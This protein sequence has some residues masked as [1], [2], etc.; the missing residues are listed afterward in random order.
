M[1]M[2]TRRAAEA[3]RER[4]EDKSVGSKRKKWDEERQSY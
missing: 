4:M 2:I 1:E 3:I